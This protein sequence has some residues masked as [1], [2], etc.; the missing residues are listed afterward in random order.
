MARLIVQRTSEYNNRLRHFR[1][2]IDGEE[3]DKIANG[4]TMEFHLTPGRHRLYSKIDW[5]S[6]QEISFDISDGETKMF[7]LGGFR[8]GN[9]I[10]PL[11]VGFVVLGSLFRATAGVDYVLYL[12]IPG[13]LL[14]VYYLTIGRKKYLTLTE[15]STTI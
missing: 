1:I 7:K 3:V 2:F 14:L 11:S 5:C 9:W 6:S 13:F 15:L 10:I 8:H 4:E 12:M